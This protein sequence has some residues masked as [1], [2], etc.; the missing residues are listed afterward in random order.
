M[1][2]LNKEHFDKYISEHKLT[3]C[4]SYFRNEYP[5]VFEII[6]HDKNN[7]EK[8]FDYFGTIP[9]NFPEGYLG[10]EPI[11][12]LIFEADDLTAYIN[13]LTELRDKLLKMEN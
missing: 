7:D 8:L 4:Q 9:I 13:K 12:N 6:I 3:V 5:P 2:L 11:Y 10:D 1:I